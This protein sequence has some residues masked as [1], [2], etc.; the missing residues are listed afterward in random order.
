MAA[1]ISFGKRGRIAELGAVSANGLL[2]ITCC[3]GETIRVDA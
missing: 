2:A 1:F 3:P